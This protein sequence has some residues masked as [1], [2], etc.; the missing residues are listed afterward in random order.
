MHGAR[1]L[2][3]KVDCLALPV[4]DLDAAIAF[5]ASLGHDVAGC[6]AVALRLPDTEAELVLQ[7]ERPD[8]E[9][10]LTVRAVGEAVER[11]VAAGGRVVVEEFDLPI[12]RCAVVADPWGNRLVLLD[13]SKGHDVTDGSGAVTGIE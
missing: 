4:P 12:G 8:A 7:R 2:I 10:D 3:R 9:T 6:H 11:F 13:T 1:P 5:D